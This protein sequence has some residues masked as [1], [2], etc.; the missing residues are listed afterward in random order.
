MTSHTQFDTEEPLWTW[1]ADSSDGTRGAYGVTNMLT[2]ARERLLDAL[3]AMPGAGKGTIR[4][5]RLEIT[6]RPSPGYVHGVAVMT[7]ERHQ[8]GQIT[9]RGQLL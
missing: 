7:G 1:R 8:T 9:I 6:F 5:A 2:V 4:Q 3:R